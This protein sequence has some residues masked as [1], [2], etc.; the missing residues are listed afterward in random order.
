M[1]LARV[2][3][4]NVKGYLHGGMEAW[5][6]AGFEMM[7]VPQRSA[8]ELRRLMDEQ[9]ELQIIDVR[10]AAEYASGHVPGAASAPLAPQ[11]ATSLARLNL[12]PVRPTAVICAGGYR[13][14]AACSLLEQHGFHH[15]Y[16]IKGGTGA[17]IDAG[18]PV[19]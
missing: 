16:N 2:G 7:S 17:W 13:S 12:D 9:E 14:S 3:L 19:E 15:L 6:Q 8:A 10:R 18:Y 4:E 1:R 5:S 11:L